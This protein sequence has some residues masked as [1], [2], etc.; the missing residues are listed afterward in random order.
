MNKLFGPLCGLIFGA[1][2]LVPFAVRAEE[3]ANAIESVTATQQGSL[4]ILRFQ[5][6]EPLKEVPGDG[7]TQ[8]APARIVLD[9]PDTSNG[10]GKSM[11]DV[12]QGELRTINVVEAGNRTRVVFNLKRMVS[13]QKSVQGNVLIVTL[14]GEPAVASA[15]TTQFAPA[16]PSSAAHEVRD[17]DFRTGKGGEGR[18]V[19]DL[20]DA[21][22]G[23]DIRTQGQN[24]VLEFVKTKLPDALRRK[25]DVGDFGTPVRV[26]NTFQQGDNVRMVIEPTGLW[27][28]NAYQSDNRF[29]LEVKA[30]KE[31]PN[32]LVQGTRQGYKGEK[33]SLNFQNV[34]V[35]A[36]LQ[37]IADFT[38]LNIIASETVGG[39]ITLRLKDVPWDQALDI[40]MQ[41]KGLDMRKRGNVLWIAPRD[42]LTTKE[43]LEFEAKQ[44]ISE[45]EPLRTESFQLNYQK[46]ENFQK[47]LTDEKQRI[48]SKR[49]SAVIDPRTNQLFVQDIPS[50]LEEMRNLLAKIDVA[51]R[52]VLIEARI[53]EA[54]DKFSRNLGAKLGFT[55][56]SQNSTT[57]GW[58]GRNRVSV[59]GNY[60]GVGEQNGQATVTSGSYIPDTQ[61]V[62]LPAGAINGATP[63][64]FAISLFRQGALK[65]LNLEISALEADGRG[66]IISSPRVVT[67]DNVEALIEQGEEIPYLQ[68]S[69]SGAT[70]IAF[71]KA[72][73]SLKVKPQI[74][75]EGNVVLS[76]EVNKD[77][78]GELAGGVPAINTK[79]VQTEVMVENGGTV[80]IGGIYQQT[81]RN[82]VTKVPLLG[83]IPVLGNLFKTK[84]RQDD[85]T[86]LL[87]FLTPK[88]LN[89]KL[90]ATQQ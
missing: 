28:H 45:L 18:V 84:S 57:A 82:D 81:E 22:T 70:N 9:F 27:E 76:V 2:L 24:I 39:N 26:I 71:K 42:E 35:R 73:L 68:A 41:A 72:V 46:A 51:A 10:L 77:S 25:L 37:V 58:G 12:S 90:T 30:I 7:F 38:N 20:S 34:E 78:R 69:S 8:A 11:V 17:I 29:V 87:I 47:I 61:F 89:E 74:T 53:V 4:T 16:K 52:Q 59:T 3:Q 67:A 56:L 13:F 85:K 40:I 32:K 36:L 60:L 43:K 63:G 48:L 19:V 15:N 1:M 23:V 6:K 64:S 49:G 80:V 83:D 5:L 21:D 79:K 14:G 86:E 88:V 54:D 44:Q 33:L 31:D 66:K 65:F 55:D 62:S 75:P 50:K